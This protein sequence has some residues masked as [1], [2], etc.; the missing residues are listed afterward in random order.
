MQARRPNKC[1]AR[2][3]DSIIPRRIFLCKTCYALLPHD[4]RAQVWEAFNPDAV[5]AYALS[6]KIRIAREAVALLKKI[7]RTA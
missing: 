5:S 4:L 7:A 1:H 6:G 2:G 3:C